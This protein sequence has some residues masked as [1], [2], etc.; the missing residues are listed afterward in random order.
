MTWRR[1]R[2]G[3]LVPAE[4]AYSANAV[5]FDESNDYLTRGAALTGEADGKTGLFSVWVKF[6]SSASAIEEFVRI[7]GGTFTIQRTGTGEIRIRAFNSTPTEILLADTTATFDDTDGW[8]HILIAWDLS[9]T[10]VQ[11]YINDSSDISVSTATN[12]DIDLTNTDWGIG[13]RDTGIELLGADVA[14]FYLN[15][16]ETLDI[17][18]EANR[19]KFIDASGKP[20]DLGSDGSTPTG[21]APIIYLH[22]ATDTWHT[23]DGSGGGFTENGELTTA[24]SSPSD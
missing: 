20:V 24:G 17:S 18:S 1:M 7:K 4:I 2:S 11:M 3:L 10:T 9:T 5:T 23:N 13:G 22:G 21:T 19:R 12:D 6:D 16:A 15:L 8:I 14:D